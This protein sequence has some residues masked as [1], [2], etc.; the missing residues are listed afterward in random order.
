[1]TAGSKTSGRG[2]RHDHLKNKRA[3]GPLALLW[4]RLLGALTLGGLMAAI[5]LRGAL[6]YS[7]KLIRL[8]QLVEMGW[9]LGGAARGG[10]T[11]TVGRAQPA[12]S[13]WLWG[14]RASQNGD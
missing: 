1:V 14:L 8:Y 3:R 5:Y 7:G 12:V 4:F 6:P 10:A 11:N 9:G 2:D 13:S